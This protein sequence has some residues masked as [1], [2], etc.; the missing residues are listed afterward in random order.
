[1][2]FYRYNVDGDSWSGA[3]AP[4]P[5]SGSTGSRKSKEGGCGTYLNGYVYALKGG[6]TQEFWHYDFLQK[7]WSQNADIPL[8]M[9][10]RRVKVKRGSAMASVDSTIFALKG[11]G[12][13]E[14]WE[15]KAGA[16]SLL[17]LGDQPE[18]EGVM[19]DQGALD[20]SRPWLVAY[21]NPTS[22]GLT[23]SYNVTG[24]APTH[25]RI[26]DAAGKLVASLLNATR[27]RGQYVAQW[28][29]LA[30]GGSRIA[31]G[32]YFVKLES[33]ESRLTQKFIVQR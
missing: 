14:F 20:L 6:N 31:A 3:L 11:S 8:A 2:A 28:N 15:Y 21:P 12:S 26:Y 22:V 29:A 25:L 32:V 13:Y 30:A 27:E 17:V 24:T 5:I 1:M 7:I 4:M 16:D 19:A 10:G 23:I 33:G 9:S 18:R